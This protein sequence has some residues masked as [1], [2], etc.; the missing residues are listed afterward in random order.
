MEGSKAHSVRL[1]LSLI[2]NE[3]E[4]LFSCLNGTI[5]RVGLNKVL[6]VVYLSVV[7]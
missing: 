3:K 5:Q 2:L 7:L 4:R 1:Q 6:S